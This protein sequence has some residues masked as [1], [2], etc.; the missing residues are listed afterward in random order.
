MFRQPFSNSSIRYKSNKI[1][2]KTVIPAV[3]YD[4]GRNG[5]AYFDTDTADYHISGGNRGGNRGRVYRNDGVDI[6]KDSST[7]NSYY[8]SNTEPGEWLQYTCFVPRKG[9]YSI[10]LEVTSENGEGKLS[11][12]LNNKLIAKT[13]AVQEATNPGSWQFLEI[14]DVL[15]NKGTNILRV[16]INEGGLNLKSLQFIVNK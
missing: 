10:R 5:S 13:L 3:D 16:H 2:N 1:T 11:L 12:S 7:E 8:I 14:K 9:K 6:R 15:L 4:L